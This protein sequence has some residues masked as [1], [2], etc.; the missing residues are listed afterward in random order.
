[1]DQNLEGSHK[2]YCKGMVMKNCSSPLL[3]TNIIIWF[4]VLID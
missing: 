2:K 1:M 3:K 4:L